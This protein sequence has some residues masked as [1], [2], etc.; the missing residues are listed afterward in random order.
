VSDRSHDQRLHDQTPTR[1]SVLEV[2]RPNH[3]SGSRTGSRTRK[4]K[5]KIDELN[6]HKEAYK[7]QGTQT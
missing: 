5:T 1:C 2:Q 4:T 7:R 3:G 6:T